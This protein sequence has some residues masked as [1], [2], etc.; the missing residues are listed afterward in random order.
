MLSHLSKMEKY[1]ESFE[2]NFS[3]YLFK[4][5]NEERKCECLFVNHY[6]TLVPK[7]FKYKAHKMVVVTGRVME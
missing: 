2:K 4:I 3:V 1:K 5:K 7:I 6:P